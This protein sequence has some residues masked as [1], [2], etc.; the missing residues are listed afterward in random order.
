MRRRQQV[1]DTPHPALRVCLAAAGQE[2][3]WAAGIGAREHAK[4]ERAGSETVGPSLCKR[5]A[6]YSV[7]SGNGYHDRGA[8]VLLFS[9]M[10]TVFHDTPP[11]RT[12]CVT[13]LLR[14]SE[15]RG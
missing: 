5:R 12:A 14:M 8:F 2:Q 7:D 9:A 6:A 15:M 13:L 10:I 4:G 3:S 1:P 11:E